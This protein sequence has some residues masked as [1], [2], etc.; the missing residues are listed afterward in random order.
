MKTFVAAHVVLIL[1]T[2]LLRLLNCKVES[3]LQLQTMMTLSSVERRSAGSRLPT[4][5]RRLEIAQ[6]AVWL[7]A[8][9]LLVAVRSSH[10]WL[11][12]YVS[13]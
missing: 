1:N 13:R 8:V 6:M 2:S 4:A 3:D 9:V 5:A 11:A 12:S 7:W 10:S